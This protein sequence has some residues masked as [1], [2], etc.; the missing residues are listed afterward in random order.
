MTTHFVVLLG[1]AIVAALVVGCELLSALTGRRFA[2][3]AELL[4]R[5]TARTG[6]LVAVFVGW[7]WLGW[8]LFA[9]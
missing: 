9:R 7:M 6:W 3:L 8:H 2:G 5:L 1:W 4:E